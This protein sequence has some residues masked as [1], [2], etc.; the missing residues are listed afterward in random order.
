VEDSFDLERFVLAQNT[1]AIYDAAIEELR[2]GQKQSHWMWFVFPQIAGLGRSSNANYYAI[3]S[4]KEAKAYLDHP[5]LG[6]RLHECTRAVLETHDRTAPDIF[7]VIDAMKLHSSMTLFMRAAPDDRLFAEVLKR[8]FA[9]T[10][11]DRTDELLAL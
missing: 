4:L 11:D 2:R 7:G 6:T 10:P 9:G 1:G 8:Y 3:S 5:L